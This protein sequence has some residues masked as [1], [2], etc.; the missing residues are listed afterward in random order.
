MA[1]FVRCL[2]LLEVEYF[3]VMHYPPP[4]TVRLISDKLKMQCLCGTNPG[5][6]VRHAYSWIEP[7][8]TL[9]D[10][11]T[12]KGKQREAGDRDKLQEDAA[13]IIQ[14][15]WRQHLMR[16][17]YLTTNV[18]WKDTLINIKKKVKQGMDI[19]A[20]SLIDQQVVNKSA[21]DDRQNDPKSRWQ[22]GVFLAGRLRNGDA[23]IPA[24]DKNGLQQYGEEEPEHLK[25]LHTQHWLE[26][27]DP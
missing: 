21:E 23:I 6:L 20:E 22:R 4:G 7:P 15:A 26:L 16:K 18:R 11:I 13:T 14:R 12:S 27:V 25:T 8:H 19:D 1:V 24:D 10:V 5:C 2:S 3:Q 9:M 17:Q